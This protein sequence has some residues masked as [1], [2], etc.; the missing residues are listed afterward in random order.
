MQRY[1][2]IFLFC[3]W[4]TLGQA[5][6]LPVDQA[7]RA[8]ITYMINCQGCHTSDGSGAPGRVPKVNDYMGKF[9]HVDGGRE[10]LVRVPGSANA[11]VGDAELAQ[12]LNWMLV[13]FS[14][15]EIPNDF[16]P[17]TEKEIAVWR[18]S[19]LMEVVD[20]RAALVEKIDQLPAIEVY[21]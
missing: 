21:D 15:K 6:E 11:P 5:Y 13:T 12:L 20:V 1:L 8:K 2:F 3:I 10:F 9:L 17:Y 7:Q 16:K 19:P 4:P 14:P 18:R